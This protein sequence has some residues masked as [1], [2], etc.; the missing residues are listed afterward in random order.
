MKKLTLLALIAFHFLYAQYAFSLCV[1]IDK[2]ELKKGPGKQ[3]KTLWIVGQ[4][5]PL[6]KLSKTAGWYKVQDMDNEI[7][8]IQS[9][10]V[11]EAFSC[12]VVKTK[13]A[14]LKMAPNNSAGLAELSVVDKYTPFKKLDRQDGYFQVT[15]D[16]DK[17]WIKD[18]SVW[19]PV[20]KMN[21]SF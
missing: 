3:F 1:S 9:S 15:N 17:F 21:I 13:T 6:K 16:F 14:L 8:W 4:Y 7:Y 11:T 12:V 5:M 20:N 19:Y 2:A 10:A 18:T